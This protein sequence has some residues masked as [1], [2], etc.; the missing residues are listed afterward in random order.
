MANTTPIRLREPRRHHVRWVSLRK[1]C[2]KQLW[3]HTPDLPYGWYDTFPGMCYYPQ[4]PLDRDEALCV[5]VRCICTRDKGFCPR[6]NG[7]TKRE[8]IGHLDIQFGPRWG[9]WSDMIFPLRSGHIA[10]D[11]LF[12]VLQERSMS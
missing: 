7:D 8:W 4:K 6:V 1:W 2:E 3:P 9:G 12:R 10:A 5:D 11:H